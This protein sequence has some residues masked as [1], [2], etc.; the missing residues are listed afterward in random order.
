M[1][2]E[3]R[4]SF[5]QDEFTALD[6]RAVEERANEAGKGRRRTQRILARTTSERYATVVLKKSF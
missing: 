5:A 6:V 4:Q 2:F 3:E 1:D